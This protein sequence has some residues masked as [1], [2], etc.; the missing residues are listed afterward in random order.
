MN[1]NN[2][3]EKLMENVENKLRKHVEN[4]KK[5][6]H[7]YASAAILIIAIM[8]PISVFA[9]SKYY[10]N[11]PFKQEID[12]AR[13]NNNVSKVNKS[14][15]Y[16]NIDFTIKDIAADETGIEVIY[17]VSNPKYYIDGLSFKDADN[18]N[19]HQW[20]YSLPDSSNNSDKKEKAFFISIGKEE[21]KYIQKNPITINID[22]ISYKN[23]EYN[24]KILAKISS[25]IN[26]KNDSFK[27]NWNLK[28]QIT[29]QNVKNLP[30]NKEYSLNIGTLK[31]KNLK[32]GILKTIVEY[33]FTPSNGSITVMRPLFSMRLDN[34]YTDNINE[35]ERPGYESSGYVR[36]EEF[37]SIY[38]K[39]IK[40]VGI[41]LVGA[42]VNYWYN[43]EY[44]ISK[45]KLP[46]QFD[47]NGE[48]LKITSMTQ[49]D[50]CTEYNVEYDKT[51]RIY[52][53]IGIIPVRFS[54]TDNYGSESHE[55]NEKVQFKDQA[56]RNTVYNTLIKKAPNLSSIYNNSGYSGIG[57]NNAVVSENFSFKGRSVPNKFKIESAARSFLYDT[58]EI[59]IKNNSN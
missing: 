7:F 55:K 22:N 24:N 12:L 36:A 56:S 23:T 30:I 26:P 43:K 35:E 39:N 41:R 8:L 10:N 52:E 45:D 33:D 54:D 29:M 1:I 25:F 46:M 59:V 49:K 20:G 37:K 9:Y 13:Q 42:S 34:N 15:K 14:F 18:K 11:I 40:E 48:K 51:N 17:N 50:D 47:F 58:D 4:K 27:V 16:K 32:E 2:V 28:T 57:V 21:A 3:P 19:F 44:E 5:K 31:L 53:R 6:L 38:Y